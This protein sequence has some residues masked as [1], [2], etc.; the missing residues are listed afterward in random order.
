MV[1]VFLTPLEKFHEICHVNQWIA[2]KEYPDK[3]KTP[4]NQAF[5]GVKFTRI[6]SKQVFLREMLYS[7]ECHTADAVASNLSNVASLFS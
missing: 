4:S 3:C 7:Q 1:L 2:L 5:E 6:F